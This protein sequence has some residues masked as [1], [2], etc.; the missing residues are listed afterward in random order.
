MRFLFFISVYLIS[1]INLSNGQEL[2][3]GNESIIGEVKKK[4]S[5][6]YETKDE[7][8]FFLTKQSLQKSVINGMSI[9]AHLF[10]KNI[11]RL[12]T[13]G[14]TK[15]GRLSTEWYFHDKKLI[16][17]YQVFEYFN[18]YKKESNWKNF[19]GLYG[20]ESRYYFLNEKLE[21]HQHKGRKNI[22]SDF[23]ESRVLRDAKSIL[24]YI[25][26]KMEENE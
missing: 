16:F 18:E 26:M 19:K 8:R 7:T 20:W 9:T 12:I 1:S 11:N 22:N 5:Q 21:F 14:N 2:S 3:Y 10:E 13:T 17:V 24:N 23:K 15:H 4:T 25:K 6:I